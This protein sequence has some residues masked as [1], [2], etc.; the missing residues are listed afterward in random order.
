[1]VIIILLVSLFVD[2]SSSV[3]SVLMWNFMT[4]LLELFLQMEQSGTKWAKSTDSLLLKVHMWV[5]KSLPH[6]TIFPAC[7]KYK[8]WKFQ[9]KSHS[10]R[11]TILMEDVHSNALNL[12]KET[13][14]ERKYLMTGL[15][16]KN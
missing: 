1:M 14:C 3:F 13:H 15:L 10:A 12:K 9:H 11:D 5:E 7:A 16:D 6:C 4:T 8:H 2:V